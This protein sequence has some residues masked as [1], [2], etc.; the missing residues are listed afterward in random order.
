MVSAVPLSGLTP[1]LYAVSSSAP[2]NGG[3]GAGL[4]VVLMSFPPVNS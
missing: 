1:D 3:S 2:L 4:T